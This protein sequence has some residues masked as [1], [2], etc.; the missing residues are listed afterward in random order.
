MPARPVALAVEAPEAGLEQSAVHR[1]PPGHGRSTG[2][3]SR[4]AGIRDG[5]GARQQAPHAVDEIDL[6]GCPRS[7]S[8]RE[9]SLLE[10]NPSRARSRRRTQS[11]PL[12]E[13]LSVPAASRSTSLDEFFEIRVAGPTQKAEVG[14]V[15]PGVDQM[16]P[17]EARLRAIS[18]RAQRAGRGGGCRVP[19]R[20]ADPRSSPSRASA[21][22]AASEPGAPSSSPGSAYLRERAPAG[23]SRRSGPTRLHPFP[24]ILRQVAFNFIVSPRRQGGRLR[25]SAAMPAIVVQAPPALPARDPAAAGPRRQRPARL[26]LLT[27]VIHTVGE[28]LSPGT[29][30]RGCY[31]FR[32]TR[33]SHLFGRRGGDG[34]D[35]LLAL[36][37]EPGLAALRA[38]GVRL[39]VAHGADDMADFLLARVRPRAPNCATRSTARSI[40]IALLRLDSLIDRADLE[41]APFQAVG[42]RGHG[43]GAGVFDTIARRDVL[44]HHPYD[45]FAPVRRSACQAAVDSPGARRSSQTLYR[46]GADYAGG[47]TSSSRRPRAPA[48]RSPSSSSCVPRFDEQVEHRR[49]PTACRRRARVVMPRRRL[50]DARQDGSPSCGARSVACA[51]TSTSARAT[52]HTKTAKLYP[53]YG[54]LTVNRGLRQDVHNMFLQL[55]QPRAGARPQQAG[56]T[57]RSRA[58]PRG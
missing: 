37:A 33:N 42:A 47:G 28:Q 51:T 32:V 18:G 35:L 58:A 38:T 7:T 34:D 39:E 31:Q 44:L 56:C 14:A 29:R 17:A 5:P 22:C 12:L 48:R 57:R 43:A 11:N 8:T 40:S 21:S 23:A 16:Q 54:L 13:R 6:R 2:A 52:P 15:P 24:R 30:V 3:P 45:S 26:V 55:D 50:Q 19:R 41:D 36:E 27:S 53:D 46:R 9:L 10:F 1:R 20:R 4:R 25:R 49:S